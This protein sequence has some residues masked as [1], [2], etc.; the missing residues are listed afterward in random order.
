MDEIRLLIGTMLAEEDRLYA[1]RA[2]REE[3]ESRAVLQDELSADSPL[4]SCSS[5]PR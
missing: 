4:R 5:A 3:S 2:A 1:E